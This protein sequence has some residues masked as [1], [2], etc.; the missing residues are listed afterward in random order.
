MLVDWFW[1]F[2]VEVEL[3]DPLLL[4][5]LLKPPLLR[6][7]LILPLL[8]PLLL[9][10]EFP[11]LLL[12]NPKL[13]WLLELLFVL[14]GKEGNP[15]EVELSWLLPPKLGKP[16]PF[17]PLLL[18]GLPK[19][20]NPPVPDEVLLVVLPND[21]KPP[22]F[23]WESLLLPNDGNP[24][25]FA[26]VSLLLLPNEGNPPP[27]VDVSL[28][29]LF[30]K[31]GNPPLLV[32]VSLVLVFPNDGNPPP[33]AWVSLLLL[34]ND[35]N[36]PLVVDVS[37][38]VL[39]PND[40]NPPPLLDD[41]LLF[42]NDGNPPLLLDVSLLLLPND[43]NPPV[44]DEVLVVSLNDRNA[45]W[46][47]DVLDVGW[48]SGFVNEENKSA[49]LVEV[50]DGL[51][52]VEGLD[53]SPNNP[54]KRDEESLSLAGEGVGVGLDSGVGEGEG[55]NNP[56]NKE[57][58]EESSVEPANGS[59]GSEICGFSGSEEDENMGAGLDT[60][61]WIID[62]SSGVGIWFPNEENKSVIELESDLVSDLVSDS[63]FVES[64]LENGPKSEKME[65]SESDFESCVE[66]SWVC[67][68]G[69]DVSSFSSDLGLANKLQLIP[70]PNILNQITNLG[71]SPL[72]GLWVGL[73]DSNWPQSIVSIN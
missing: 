59:L 34:P 44:P 3:L 22:L 52:L 51:S 64:G 70:S 8:N 35:G 26:W 73:L 58:F 41:S 7:S 4:G 54:P 1:L 39:L 38:L 19:E 65:L 40:G 2:W 27:V 67:D 14:F 49:K 33:F 66:L 9:L 16:P 11:K 25:P 20:G 17:D 37:L 36:P 21:G 5:L 31:D 45:S 13:F 56:P 24:P 62:S 29:V 63:S 53:K 12:P 18:L 10:F 48:A 28:L 61:G 71:P 72:S 47:D 23:V 42:P 68:G 69:W 43:G 46:F 15:P 60:E 55:E 30:P 50:S 32:D 6:L 57:S